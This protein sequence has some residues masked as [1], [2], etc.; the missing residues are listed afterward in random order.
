MTARI[1]RPR[2]DLRAFTQYGQRPVGNAARL[3]ANE[4][5]EPNPA[6]RYLGQAE[7][8]RLVLNR[9]PGPGPAIEIRQI[10]AKQ[11][12]V[13]PDQLLFGNGSNDTIMQL[14]LVFGGHGRTTLLFQPTYNLHGRFTVIAGGTLANEMVGLPYRVTRERALE[15]AERVHP[16]I[17]CFCTPNNPTGTVVDDD[18]I[19][20]VAERHPETLVL[21]DEAYADIAGRTVLPAVSD[22]PNLVVSKTFSKVHA[23]AGLRFGILVLH[24][25]LMGTVRNVSVSFNVSVVTYALAAKIARDEASV[26]RRIAQVRAERER[27]FAEMQKMHGIEPFPS[28]ANFILFRVGGDTGAHQARFLEQGVAIRDMAPWTGAQGCLR[29]SIGTREEN[30]RFLAALASVFAPTPA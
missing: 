22:H 5:P 20:S 7:L 10:L 19:L 26:R 21:V 2:E 16:D 17:V 11:Y 18:V 14:F 24:P 3:N 9:Y 13:D 27:V 15:A 1:P 25:A 4:W 12:G 28:E 29:V 30:D 8:D 23:A 6:A